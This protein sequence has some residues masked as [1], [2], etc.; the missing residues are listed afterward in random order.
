MDKFIRA[1]S[2]IICL[3]SFGGG[4]AVAG[5]PA[6][7]ALTVVDSA[8]ADSV[9]LAGQVVY[10]DFWASWCK[11]CRQSLPWLNRMQQKYGDDGFR[12]I[13]VNVDRDRKAADKFMTQADTDIRLVYDPDGDIARQYHLV[14]MPTGYIY[15]R[16]GTFRRQELG[17]IPADTSK[18]ESYIETLLKEDQPQ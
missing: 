13:G 6:P 14:G 4:L 5:T 18:L 10:V 8:L 11:P 3:V 15:G 16:D 12:A 7:P 9:P 1:I 2:F 17:F